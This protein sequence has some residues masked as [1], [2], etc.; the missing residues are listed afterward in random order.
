MKRNLKRV[1]TVL[2]SIVIVVLLLGIFVPILMKIENSKYDARVESAYAKIQRAL[3]SDPNHAMI[4]IS[5]GTFSV[6][7][8]M[9][10]MYRRTIGRL[11]A[12]GEG[13]RLLI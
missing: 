8:G 5:V 7:R 13:T 4:E 9:L 10:P 12:E 2:A 6:P 11:P 3:D 1:C